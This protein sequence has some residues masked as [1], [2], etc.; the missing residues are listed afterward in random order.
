[1]SG[2]SSSIALGGVFSALCLLFMF[3]TGLVPFA[4]YALPALAGAMLV[5]VVIENGHRT[6]L[7]VYVSVSVLSVF[8]VPDRE[9]AAVF[10][11][12]FGY[13]P[14]IKEKLE[15][16][17]SRLVEYLIKFGLFNIMIIAA[18]LALTYVF[19]LPLL[20]E[21]EMGEFGRYTAV[22]LLVAGNVVFC[23]YDFALTKYVTLYVRWFKPRFLRR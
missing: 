17:R 5:A 20:T 10:I 9:A 3:L 16:M 12:F 1:M 8:I 23:L 21:E 15:A 19:G 11:A 4:T 22:I 6:A 2:K 18:Y 14:I 7:M 13:Y